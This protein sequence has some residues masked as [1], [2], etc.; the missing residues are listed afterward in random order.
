VHLGPAGRARGLRLNP[1]KA[2]YH[3]LRE[4]TVAGEHKVIFHLQRPQPW[5]LALPTDRDP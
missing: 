3:N 1:R 5:F 4:V 2:W